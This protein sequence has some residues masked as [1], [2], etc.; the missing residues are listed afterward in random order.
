MENSKD[1]RED[2]HEHEHWFHL[3]S[4]LAADENPSI[5]NLQRNGLEDDNI[6]SLML[7]QSAQISQFDQLNGHHYSL[8]GDTDTFCGTY[9]IHDDSSM[10]IDFRNLRSMNRST[11]NYAN[12]DLIGNVDLFND[13]A[14]DSYIPDEMNY[15]PVFDDPTVRNYIS[16][17]ASAHDYFEEVEDLKYRLLNLDRHRQDICQE[18]QTH[19]DKD[20][21][22]GNDEKQNF[23]FIDQNL[24]KDSEPRLLTENV[25]YEYKQA[26]QKNS[27]TA[28]SLTQT[29][30][31]KNSICRFEGID[32]PRT[33]TASNDTS[34][35]KKLPLPLA[36]IVIIRNV[37]QSVTGVMLDLSG[38]LTQRFCNIILTRLREHGQLEQFLGLI[39][40]VSYFATES[41]LFGIDRLHSFSEK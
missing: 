18:Y 9:D 11:P 14:F 29:S 32:H 35:L 17:D 31:K 33:R 4:D 20:F 16:V 25:S 23:L 26:G 41:A 3:L 30:A 1:L 39:T 38:A 15:E 6:F 27:D 37:V 7:S 22:C 24:A 2:Y 13:Q 36:V 34:A 21:S 12:N 10:Q 40:D 19:Y 8:E 5:E 28:T